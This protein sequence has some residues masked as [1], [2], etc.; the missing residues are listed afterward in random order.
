MN[1]GTALISE[2]LTYPPTVTVIIPTY[3]SSGILKLTLDSVLRQNFKDYEVWIIGDGCT[4]NSEQIVTSFKDQRLHWIN[5]QKNSGTPS[6]PRNEG[7]RQAKGQYIAYL[8]HDD[9]WF[10]WHL[11]ELIKYI[12]QSEYDFVY[13]LGANIGP[14]GVVGFFSLPENLKSQHGGL[15][16]SNWLHKQ[17]LIDAVGQWSLKTKVSDDQEFL[18][19]IWAHKIKT[20]FYPQLSVLKF[21]SIF[22]KTYSLSTNFPQTKYLNAMTRN[23]E[24]LRLDVLLEYAAALSK[25][26]RG[27]SRRNQFLEPIYDLI[28]FIVNFYGRH[29]WPINHFLYRRYRRKSGL[30]AK[31]PIHLSK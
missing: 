19:R 9:L 14:E 10:P 15:S 16:P 13:S 28:R 8:G 6:K 26:F 2:K 12:Q 29:R 5:L 23:A 11:E 25:H 21:P 7:L 1:N 20:G 27:L 3:N 17:T 24:L 22:W 30:S 4:D 31:Q 18:Q